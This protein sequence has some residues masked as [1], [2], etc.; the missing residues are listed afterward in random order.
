MGT[1]FLKELIEDSSFSVLGSNISEE[2]NFP[3]KKFHHLNFG[4]HHIFFLGITDPETIINL[5]KRL[6]TDPYQGLATGISLL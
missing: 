1:D 3:H 5:G 4:K 6:F 2:S